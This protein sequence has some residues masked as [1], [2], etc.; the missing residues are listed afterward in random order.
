[1]KWAAAFEKARGRDRGVRKGG[2]GG[3]WEWVSSQAYS[4]SFTID[5]TPT[6]FV[7]LK[8]TASRIACQTG[9]IKIRSSLKTN[10]TKQKL[11][12]KK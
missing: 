6:M 1:M 4:F 11:K 5:F 7:A 9:Y 10:K 12:N 2:R 8:G 3:G